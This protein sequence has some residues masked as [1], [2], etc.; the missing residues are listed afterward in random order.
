MH[1]EDEHH[2]HEQKQKHSQMQSQ[3]VRRTNNAHENKHMGED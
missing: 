3:R 1:N 2:K